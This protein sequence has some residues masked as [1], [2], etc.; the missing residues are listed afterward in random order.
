VR[1]SAVPV[2][3]RS[4]RVGEGGRG[5]SQMPSQTSGRGIQLMAGYV[6]VAR[7]WEM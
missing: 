2:H 4:D 6:S 1:T 7:V 3:L 5:G